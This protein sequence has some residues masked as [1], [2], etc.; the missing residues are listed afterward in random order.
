MIG[1]LAF[2]APRF[3]AR[4]FLFPAEDDNPTARTMG[5]LFGVRDAVLGAIALSTSEP[6][7]SARLHRMTAC[8]DAGDAVAGA[9]LLRSGKARGGAIMVLVAAI[10]ATVSGVLIAK[11]EDERASRG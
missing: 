1:V 2:V 4:L 7:A 3:S 5:R 6:K 8:V 10:S 9:I 11:A